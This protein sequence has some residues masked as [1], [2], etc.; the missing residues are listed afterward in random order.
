MFDGLDDPA[1]DLRAA[2]LLP[3]V[4]ARGRRLRR[5]RRAGLA[6]AGGATLAVAVAGV[7]VLLPGRVGTDLLV[8]TDQGPGRVNGTGVPTPGPTGL[9]P[10]AAA[11]PSASPASPGA[12]PARGGTP[13][14]TPSGSAPTAAACR[15][16][17]LAVSV[18]GGGGGT[19]GS[20]YTA[21]R[22]TRRGS[23][24][25]TLAGFPDVSF[26]GGA[27]SHQVGGAATHEGSAATVTLGPG[28]QA[29][30]TL[31]IGDYQVY[32]PATCRAASVTGYRI[33]LPGATSNDLIPATGATCSGPRLSLLTIGPVQPGPPTA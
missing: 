33:R 9:A 25:C 3:G 21:V 26:V 4:T 29:H 24:S 6:A 7:L 32:D 11:S 20:T 13:T 8:P 16:S 23:G 31:R 1:P 30:A 12:P 19:A 14:T 17:E 28:G 5:Q 10:S 27:D 18:G 2:E 15:S 22:I